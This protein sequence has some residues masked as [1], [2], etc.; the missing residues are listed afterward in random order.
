[1]VI[2]SPTPSS[3]GTHYVYGHNVSSGTQYVNDHNATLPRLLAV[4]NM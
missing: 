4:H 2:M 3:S 1:M